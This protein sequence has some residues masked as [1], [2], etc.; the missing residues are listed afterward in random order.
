MKMLTLLFG[1]AMLAAGIYVGWYYSP[2]EQPQDRWVQR[3]EKICL[4][5]ADGSRAGGCWVPDSPVTPH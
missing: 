2:R 5:H 3:G 1:F 4:V